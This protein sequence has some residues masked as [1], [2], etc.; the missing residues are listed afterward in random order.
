MSNFVLVSKVKVLVNLIL[1]VAMLCHLYII[2]SSYQ[3]LSI[4]LSY[5]ADF[6]THWF[7]TL[8][9]FSVITPDIT[10]SVFKNGKFLTR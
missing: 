8:F 6:T 9:S 3:I 10:T 2:L 5:M 1:Y 7:I 4:L